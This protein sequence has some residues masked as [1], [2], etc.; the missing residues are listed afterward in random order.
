MHLPEQ[1]E[2]RQEAAWITVKD[3][4][5]Q[6][7]EARERGY[8]LALTLI[9]KLLKKEIKAVSNSIKRAKMDKT[10]E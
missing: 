7:K 10:L 9:S 8:K 4:I 2:D 5:R 3:F 1:T 6:R